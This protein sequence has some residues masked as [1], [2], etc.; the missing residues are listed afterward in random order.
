M[1]PEILRQRLAQTEE[2]VLLS[3]HHVV[4]QEERIATLERDGH[5]TAQAKRILTTFE[6]AQALH[7]ATRD[8][9]R[10]ELDAQSG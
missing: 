6:E 3:E 7:I 10:H 2:I 1:G 9:L 5:D 8:R 4:R